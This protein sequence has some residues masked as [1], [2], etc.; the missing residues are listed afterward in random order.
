M[1]NFITDANGINV[2]G[3]SF[4]V[5]YPESGHSDSLSFEE[6]SFWFKH[7]N[8]VIC[9]VLKK[10][11]VK[12]S[13]I[14]IGGGNGLQALFIQKNFPAINVALIEPGYSGC[15]TAKKRGVNHVYNC[16]FQDFDFQKFNSEIVGLFDVV[17]HIENDADFLKQLAS[18]LS[19]G[20]RIIITVPAYNWLWSDLDDYGSHY[21]R[22]N[23]KMIEDLA[24]KSGLKI[25]YFS[26][27][28]TYLIPL[29]YLLR[30]IPYKLRGGRT[31]EQILEAENKQ[32]KPSWIISKVFSWLSA[33][34][35]IFIRKSSCKF[36]AS[37]IVVF[38]V[39]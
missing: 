9:E 3:K 37:I 12:N 33:G 27:F 6:E 16:L 7:R 2:L 25:N 26:Y 24:K 36:G 22:Y 1:E 38:E 39:H 5:D 23:R 8:E 13:F 28:F 34:E 31:K 21:R 35:M 20:N 32:H 14:D 4:K 11:S 19:K 15:A 18:K 17:E 29:T 10:F 30:T